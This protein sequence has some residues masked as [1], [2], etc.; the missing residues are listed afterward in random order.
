MAS[1]QT[2]WPQG[3]SLALKGTVLQ[4]MGRA[5]V[6]WGAGV[7]CSGLHSPCAASSAM[8]HFLPAPAC[9]ACLG[10]ASGYAIYNSRSSFWLL[11][12]LPAFPTR[13]ALRSLVKKPSGARGNFVGRER[14]CKPCLCSRGCRHP[15]RTHRTVHLNW[16][17]CSVLCPSHLN[18]V[19]FKG[20]GSVLD[21]LC[22]C[23]N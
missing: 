23:R 21:G 17:D 2:Q 1:P 10:L 14:H 15:P 3:H 7:L 11:A 9:T 16:V 6:W 12:L 5:G 20:K 19:A 18:Q 4:G 8:A 13:Q 22:R